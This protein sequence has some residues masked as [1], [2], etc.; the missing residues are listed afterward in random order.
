MWGSEIALYVSYIHYEYMGDVSNSPFGHFF[1][2]LAKSAQK[3]HQWLSSIL[4]EVEQFQ[5][6]SIPLIYK[7][8]CLIHEYCNILLK[9]L[10][11]N[12][13]LSAYELSVAQIVS[14]SISVYPFYII[15]V[16]VVQMKTRFQ[17]YQILKIAQKHVYIYCVDV[18][19]FFIRSLIYFVRTFHSSNTGTICN[20]SRKCI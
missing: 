20:I 9:N 3:W 13:S 11:R 14:V 4:H 12:Q 1:Y 7:S 5:V 15:T 17:L 6:C 19:V 16:H 8:T 18:G 2:A 10:K